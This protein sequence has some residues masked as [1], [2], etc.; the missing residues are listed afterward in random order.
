MNCAMNVSPGGLTRWTLAVALCLGITVECLGITV[1]ATAA[2]PQPPS[3]ASDDITL[4]ETITVTATRS[5]RAVKDTPGQVDV[6]EA[7]EIEELGYT[8][9]SDL[10]RYLPGIYVD[11]DLTRLGSNGFNIRG[12]G[13]NRVQ[14]RIDGIPTAEQFDFGPFGI[15]QYSL[16]LD[17]L[18]RVE[19]VRS[20]GS[21]LYG[22]DALGGVVSLTTR[23]PRSYLDGGP[24]YL[25]LRGGYDGRADEISEAA[26][27]A[28]GNSL[29][30]DIF[31]DDT[32][33]GLVFYSYRDGH[34]LDNQGNVDS[35]D[36]TRTSPNP[37]DRQQ[38]NILAKLGHSLN[39][40]N[41]LEFALEWFDG[42]T[43]TNVLSSLAPAQGAA[44]PDAI[45]ALL[46]EDR[47]ERWRGSVEHSLVLQT[48]LADSLLWRAY[49]QRS[50]TEQRT[51][52]LRERDIAGVT[53]GVHRDGQ[54]TFEQETLGLELDLRKDLRGDGRQ[55]LTYGLSL[56]RD[57]FDQLR[58]RSEFLG[59][60]EAIPQSL[61]LPS[62]YFP[63]SEV[64][65][66]GVFVQGEFD[67]WNGTL[68][69]V[70]GLRLDRYD[71]DADQQ[72]SVYLSG[73]P[74]TPAPV[75]YV[76]EA[77]SPRLGAVLAL[78]EEVSI[79]GQYARGFRAPP[80]SSINNG[81]TNQ[82]GGYRT[83]PNPD[84]RP[85]TS[86]N[87]ELGLRAAFTISHKNGKAGAKRGSFSLTGFDNRYQDFIETVFLGFN[88]QVFLVEFQPQNLQDVRIRGVELAAEA[89]LGSGWNL[90]AAYT[91]IEGDDELADQPLESIAPPRLV[92]GLRYT[93][94]ERWGAELTATQVA[95]K[96]DGDLPTDSTQF[97]TPSYEVFD[98]ALWIALNDRMSLQL[99]GWNLT[100]EAY[101]QWPYVRG[102]AQTSATLDRYTSPGRNFGAQLR[103]HF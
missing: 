66:L 101:W 47:Q 39:A 49:A 18:S 45:L 50:D 15:P 59:S 68:K 38:D 97:R 76:E 102:Q 70:P 60:G 46:A 23:S 3:Q 62:K 33:Q 31:G 103:V 48:T 78:S 86:D 19:I 16:D 61:A 34:E 64:E 85:E 2:T 63:R 42:S 51:D 90:R 26:T 35:A 4:I 98:L 13:G 71:L 75:D 17:T 32:W 67:L 92:A 14:T 1:A 88:P 81:F 36:F 54:L 44:Q 8:Q 40:S 41:Q 22:S 9:V 73:N 5:E 91:W 74:G 28:V 82:A 100:D 55:V 93:A 6:V 37:I 96:S 87:Y 56:Q 52:E 11:G 21:A 84:L 57:T 72:D 58:D 95:A 12:I 89:D 29:L 20:A 24:F 10:V 99:S 80:M 27:I 30:G 53:A 94:G 69:L 25:G 65:E 77:V 83:L 79:F 43:D 7:S